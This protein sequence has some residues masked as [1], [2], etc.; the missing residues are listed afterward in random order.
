MRTCFPPI[1]AIDIRI[2][3]RFVQC[4]LRAA[5]YPP[6]VVPWCIAQWICIIKCFWPL[7]NFALCCY[8]VQL[9]MC[10]E[11]FSHIECTVRLASV[12]PSRSHKIYTQTYCDAQWKVK[13]SSCFF[14]CLLTCLVCDQQLQHC[15][16]AFPFA[17]DSTCCSFT[18][19]VCF[20][21][22]SLHANGSYVSRVT[23]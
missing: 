18:Y 9:C 20:V 21:L 22:L 4:M 14:F 13:L 1:D 6:T 23:F 8:S 2:R 19:P 15:T 16:L 10:I 12:Y 17:T 7:S 11:V 5:V 3:M